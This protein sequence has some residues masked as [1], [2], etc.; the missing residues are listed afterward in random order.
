MG[1]KSQRRKTVRRGGSANLILTA[2]IVVVAVLVIGGALLLRESGEDPSSSADVA[3]ELRD[4]PGRNTVTKAGGDEV[5]VVEFLDYQCPACAGYYANVT[6]KLESDYGDRITFV[7][8]NF[9]LDA[10]PL[11]M[12]AARAAEAA[13][14]QG[15]YRQMYHALY[16]N[17]QDWAL[18]ADGRNVSDDRQRAAAQFDRFAKDIGLDLDRFHADLASDGVQR[19]IDADLDAGN[20]VGVQSTPTIFVN[21]EKF[22]PK[23]D[24]FADVERQLRDTLTDQLD[25]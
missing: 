21:G 3:S 9:P 20:S 19:R 16:D 17:Y 22:E 24:S 5:T 1:R 15:H 2:T 25:P 6:R 13:A 10:H 11:A 23:G 18:A 4:A 7:T 14:K 8:R 12:A